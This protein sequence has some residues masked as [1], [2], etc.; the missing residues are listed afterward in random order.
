MQSLG[1]LTADALSCAW[2]R[3]SSQALAES[4]KQMSA[5]E[6]KAAIKKTNGVFQLDVKPSGGGDVQTW[7]I[8]LKKEGEVV[9]GPKGK[10]GALT[11]RR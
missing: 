1:P 4:F 5:A 10:P 2:L 11:L 7:T 6:R 3:P 9:K 8:D